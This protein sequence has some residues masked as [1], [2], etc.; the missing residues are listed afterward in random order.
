MTTRITM[1]T[2]ELR[3]LAADMRAV[4]EQL[5]RHVYPVVER[6]ALAV[7]EE[8]AAN[9][10]ASTHFSSVARTVRYDITTQSAFGTG[11]IEAE[12]GP[13][14]STG[15][16][17]L[18]DDREAANDADFT[19]G[20]GDASALAHIAIHGSPRGGGGNVPD[21]VIALDHEAPKFEKALGDLLEDLL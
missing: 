7:K 4:P 9:F 2:S 12:I 13:M 8:I 17:T 19:T 3:A 16:T 15:S 1:D 20:G 5:A 10:E 14:P 6:G 11:S 18:N 21:P